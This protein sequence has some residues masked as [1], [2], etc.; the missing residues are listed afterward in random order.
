[1]RENPRS[2][3]DSTPNGALNVRLRPVFG[4]AMRRSPAVPAAPRARP[5]PP[6]ARHPAAAPCERDRRD[7]PRAPA[8][9]GWP[10]EPGRDEP[11][12][13]HV[14]VGGVA[15]ARQEAFGR[16]PQQLAAAAFAAADSRRGR[17]V[18]V[19]CTGGDASP[20]ELAGLSHPPTRWWRYGQVH[21]RTWP[22]RNGTRRKSRII[23]FYAFDLN[24]P[25]RRGRG[26][27]SSRRAPAPLP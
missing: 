10:P 4:R 14:V 25:A 26:T 5:R 27:A 8:P 7:V 18:A 16:R 12:D 17:R 2:T 3:S 20:A 1:M 13:G 19:V 11:L 24:W 22:G 21:L 23:W 6:A 9:A 15:H